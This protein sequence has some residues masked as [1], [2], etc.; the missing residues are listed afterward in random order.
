MTSNMIYTA[1]LGG[2]FKCPRKI[3][4]ITQCSGRDKEW[5]D[6]EHPGNSEPFPVT[7]ASLLHK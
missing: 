7:I 3:H 6:E 1:A 5:L 2:G 4:L